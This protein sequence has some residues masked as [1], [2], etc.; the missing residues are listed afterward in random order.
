MV[1]EKVLL[2]HIYSSVIFTPIL[3]RILDK[4]LTLVG[5]IIYAQKMLVL[6]EKNQKFLHFFRLS[7]RTDIK[8]IR[9]ELFL[10]YK[11]II[12]SNILVVRILRTCRPL[13][14][15]E[16]DIDISVFIKTIKINS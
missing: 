1:N 14:G 11:I 5:D 7:T 4:L 6:F 10:E 13:M 12:I 3:T 16:F 9:Q 8:M 15:F 2:K